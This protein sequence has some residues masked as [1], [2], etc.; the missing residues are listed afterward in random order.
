MKW[1]EQKVLDAGGTTESVAC[2]KIILEDEVR[3][4]GFLSFA[5][6]FLLEHG[7]GAGATW[8]VQDFVTQCSSN[9]C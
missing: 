9:T 5:F 4:R 8:L 3:P 1:V 6:F 7:P 2:I